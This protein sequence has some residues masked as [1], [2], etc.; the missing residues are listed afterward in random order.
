MSVGLSRRILTLA[1]RSVNVAS[2]MPS[3]EHT[4]IR[5]NGAATTIRT[6]DLLITSEL[7]YHLSYGG[8]EKHFLIAT[9]SRRSN[10]ENDLSGNEL[11]LAPKQLLN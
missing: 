3:T 1:L 7:L 10:V 2:L 4:A 9:L 11:T 8:L 6:L 5:A